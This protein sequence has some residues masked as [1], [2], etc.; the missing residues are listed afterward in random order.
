MQAP[1]TK[2]QAL[3]LLSLP[4]EIKS[5]IVEEVFKATIKTSVFPDV[6]DVNLLT[7]NH[8]ARPCGVLSCC[9]SLKGPIDL[10]A[11]ATSFMRVCR[12]LHSLG[13]EF[14]YGRLKY[15]NVMPEFFRMTFVPRT[16]G[17]SNAS[18]IKELCFE[19]PVAVTGPT[20]ETSVYVDLFNNHM[21]GLENLVLYETMTPYLS[22][23]G[24]WLPAT[25][26]DLQEKIRRLLL[27]TAAITDSSETLKEAVCTANR[28]FKVEFGGRFFIRLMT[29]DRKHEKDSVYQPPISLFVPILISNT[30]IHP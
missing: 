27:L 7:V 3:T 11:G 28:G 17:Y 12:E 24:W 19:L 13:Q 5:R 29:D 26:A 22:Q 23:M 6:I 20:R 18:Y 8:D 2:K 9:L 25:R 4:A 15:E 10:K 14:L 16:I 21:R 30:G 1:A